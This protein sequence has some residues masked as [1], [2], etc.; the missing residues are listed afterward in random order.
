MKPFKIS[1]FKP[2]DVVIIM[3][4]IAVSLCMILGMAGNSN[5]SLDAVIKYNGTVV[6]TIKL[7]NVSTAYTF[8]VNGDIPVDILVE[9]SGVSVVNSVCN[10][11]ICE[12]TGKITKAGSSVVCLPAKVSVQ[13][14]SNTEAAVDAIVG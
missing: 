13:L 1:L 9:N 3:V 6:K 14:L 11:H 10:D 2:F 5:A 12:K 8:T 7:D 4:I